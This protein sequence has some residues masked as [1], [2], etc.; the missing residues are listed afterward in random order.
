V[1]RISQRAASFLLTLG[2]LEALTRAH[3]DAPTRA[4]SELRAPAPAF[5]RVEPLAAA[6]R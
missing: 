4:Q 5:H 6:H 2:H 3:L 1:R